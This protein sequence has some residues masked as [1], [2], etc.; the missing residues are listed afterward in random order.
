MM[1]GRA[2]GELIVATAE[3][4]VADPDS[5][6]VWSDDYEGRRAVR[7]RQ[8]VRDVTTVWFTIGQRTVTIE[9]FVLPLPDDAPGGAIAHLLHRNYRTRRLHFA[10]DPRND[11]VVTGRIPLEEL[12]EHE[13]ELALGEVYDLI[14]VSFRPLL[15][16]LRP[17]D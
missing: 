14:E 8:T 15:A 6:V 5:D 16:A 12:S 4:W 3:R 10:L 7:M 1:D 13:L 11:L 17:G 2:A 9:A